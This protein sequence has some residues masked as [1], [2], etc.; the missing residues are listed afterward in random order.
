VYLETLRRPGS[1]R[2]LDG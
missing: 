1:N 2:D